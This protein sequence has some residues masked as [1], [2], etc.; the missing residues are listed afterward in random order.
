MQGGKIIKILI[1]IKVIQLKRVLPGKLG[2][3][4]MLYSEQLNYRKIHDYRIYTGI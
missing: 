3:V 2:S 4:P 1:N